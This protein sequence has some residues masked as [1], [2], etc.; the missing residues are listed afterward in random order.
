MVMPRS[1]LH[2]KFNSAR[3]SCHALSFIVNSTRQDG[4]ATLLS[5]LKSCKTSFFPWQIAFDG[6]TPGISCIGRYGSRVIVRLA[7]IAWFKPPSGDGEQATLESS[8]VACWE[9]PYLEQPDETMMLL[10]LTHERGRRSTLAPTRTPSPIQRLAAAGT[11]IGRTLLGNPRLQQR[12]QQTVTWKSLRTL[13]P[14]LG[15]HGRWHL[16]QHCR[17][18]YRR[19]QHAADRDAG[20]AGSCTAEEGQD[21]WAR[22]RGSNAGH[23]FGGLHGPGRHGDP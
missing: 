9:T 12:A 18:E 1:F 4:H 2:C 17:R 20:L 5:P 23:G 10:D 14:R 3:W 15:R 13:V 11:R 8:A 21:G 22:R 16:T 6:D 19:F 7:D